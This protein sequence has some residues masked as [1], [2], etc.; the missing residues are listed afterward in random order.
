MELFMGTLPDIPRV[1]TALAEWLACLLC[2]LEVK[3]RRFS[4]RKL[5]LVSAAYLALMSSFLVLTNDQRI[6]YG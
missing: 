4:G 5:V 3:R 1:Y 6:S 2:I